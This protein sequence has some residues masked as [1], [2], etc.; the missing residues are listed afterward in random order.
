MFVDSLIALLSARVKKVLEFSVITVASIFLLVILGVTVRSM[1]GLIRSEIT[2]PA[3]EI[4]MAW[5]YL[6]MVIGLSAFI[7]Q[8]WIVWIG[9]RKG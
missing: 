3:L 6:V 4:S 5:I 8:M 7:V 1:G 9:E 2:T